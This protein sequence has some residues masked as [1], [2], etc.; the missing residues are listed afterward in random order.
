ML[1]I[2]VLNPDM[3]SSSFKSYTS[4]TAEHPLRW[5]SI[6]LGRAARG[7]R[8]DRGGGR[9]RVRVVGGDGFT[10]LKSQEKLKSDGSNIG[11]NG[12]VQLAVKTSMVTEWCELECSIEQHRM[13]VH[14]TVVLKLDPKPNLFS[15]AALQRRMYCRWITI[16]RIIPR[17][18]I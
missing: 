9:P 16:L 6:Q 17:S 2:A 11:S 4:S 14:R 15:A 8:G 1:A 3:I 7:A 5:C 12:S 18:T 13:F 10:W